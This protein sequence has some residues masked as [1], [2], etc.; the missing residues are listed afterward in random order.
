VSVQRR[1]RRFSRVG[2]DPLVKE[3]AYKSNG[4]FGWP[5][6]QW[7]ILHATFEVRRKKGTAEVRASLIESILH[8]SSSIFLYREFF[9]L[10]LSFTF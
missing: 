2:P 4:S 10:F 7:A 9:I 1:R 6:L 3:Q 5:G 8:F